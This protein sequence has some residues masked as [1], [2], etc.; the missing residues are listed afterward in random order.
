MFPAQP[1]SGGT[2]L[3]EAPAIWEMSRGRLVLEGMLLQQAPSTCSA[4]HVAL[5]HFPSAQILGIFGWDM[6]EP[7]GLPNLVMSNIAIE[8]GHRNSGFFHEKWGFSMIFHSYLKCWYFCD[9][10]LPFSIATG[11]NHVALR[12]A[13]SFLEHQQLADLKKEAT[14]FGK[15]GNPQ[16]L[17]MF[18]G[19]WLRFLKS[20]M[21]IPFDYIFSV[22]LK[23]YKRERGT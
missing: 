22:F 11:L 13:K 10:S 4:E 12:M 2:F 9:W 14:N 1:P 21:M 18:N 16:A 15:T 19:W 20:G 6:V 3:L 8:H 23:N 7:Q 17:K 5:L